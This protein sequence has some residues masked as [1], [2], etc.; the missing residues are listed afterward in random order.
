MNFT[1]VCDIMMDLEG[2]IRPAMYLA[3]ELNARGHSVSMVSPMMS[4]EVE[5]RLDLA[6]IIPVN[7][8]AKLA[9]R[10]SGTS[11]L[12]LET[13]A[14][15]AF[16]RL[17]SRHTIDESS[18][19]INFSQVISAPSLIW[20]LQGPPSLALKDMEK[21]LSHG[22]R[23]I[24]D[25]LRPVIDYADVKLASCMD[26]RSTLVIANSKF[27]ASMY[28]SFGVKTDCVIYPPIDC[29]TFR[30]STSTP[31]SDYILTYFG[32]E[33]KF[34]ILKII[35][36][37]GIKI[38]AFGSKTPFI[39][40]GLLKH[41]NVEFLGRVPTGELVDLYSNALFTM[42]P[43]THEPFGYVP[44][45]SMACGTPV[46]TYDFQGPS[47]Y[48]VN[49][50]TGWLVRTDAE[51]VQ[52]SIELWKEE[53]PSQTRTNCVKA[54]LKFDRRTYIEQWSEILGKLCEDQTVFPR[55]K[56]HNNNIALKA[57]SHA[58][59]LRAFS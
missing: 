44:L 21:E 57:L 51:L 52:K 30:P 4:R 27:C 36:D 37:L 56:D 54:A 7:L 50:R 15:E 40:E 6:G 26:R 25:L 10:S 22:F 16:L 9:A 5:D 12:W 17:N 3:R 55:F 32:K 49:D 8:H 59:E 14:R 2:S 13:W 35:A 31:F 41:P 34:S 18:T 19:V 53:C 58:E 11:M 46:L 29:Q 39:P 45:E 24:Y 28:S 33:T 47:E 43:F 20:Y 23:I 48:V 38:K 42:F 1:L